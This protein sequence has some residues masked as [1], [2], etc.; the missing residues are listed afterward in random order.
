MKDYEKLSKEHFNRQASIYDEKDTIY[1]SK[2]GKI[3]CNY[4]SEYLKNIDYNKL[5]DIGSGTG[6]LINMLKDKEM[7]E[8]YGLDLSEEMIKIAKSKNIENAQFILGSANKLPFDDDAFDIVTCIQS[9]HHY[10]YPNEAMREAYR[11]LKKGGLYILSD[12]GVGGI[13]AWI[14]NHILF[15]I[16]KSGD[17]HTEN[18]EGISKLMIKNGFKVIDKKQIKG[19]IYSVV[20]QK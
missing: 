6:Y 12:T 17:C 19:F 11:V 16:M 14:D 18:K 10:S 5:L 9:F 20:G 3:S 8:F 2:Y 7:A 1:Y 4:V 15:K 13:A